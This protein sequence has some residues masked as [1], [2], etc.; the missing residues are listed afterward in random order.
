MT[1]QIF[2]AVSETSPTSTYSLKQPWSVRLWS[3][4]KFHST[5]NQMCCSLRSQSTVNHT[6]MIIKPMDTS[7]HSYL[8]PPPSCS[9]LTVPRMF[10]S[11]V[12]VSLTPVS[13]RL[14]MITEHQLCNVTD[15]FAPGQLYSLTSTLL[16]RPVSHRMMSNTT[17][18][19]I[20]LGGTQ[21]T[22]MLWFGEINSPKT[23][24]K[25]ST[26][27]TPL[28]AAPTLLNLQQTFNRNCYLLLTSKTMIWEDS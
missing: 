17:L 14:R 1:V 12:L 19:E 27:K 6:P 11:E 8:M 28:F 25:F 2:F 22:L 23:K 24:L 5:L 9:Q 26:M 4:A 18:Q 3:S 10:K 21:C 7:I 20:I 13:A 16:T 15:R